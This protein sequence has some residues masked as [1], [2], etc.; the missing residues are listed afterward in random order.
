MLISNELALKQLSRL[1]IDIAKDKTT[2]ESALI[3]VC[4]FEF[5]LE[6]LAINIICE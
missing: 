1:L 2:I 5:A 6:A 3:L 4:G